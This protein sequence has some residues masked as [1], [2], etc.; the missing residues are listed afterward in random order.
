[1]REINKHQLLQLISQ[2]YYIATQRFVYTVF[3]VII[4]RMKWYCLDKLWIGFDRGDFFL[5]CGPSEGLTEY[6]YVS[7]PVTP[8]LCYRE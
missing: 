6:L 4:R 7:L 8:T 2:Q 1:M 3:A 5:W